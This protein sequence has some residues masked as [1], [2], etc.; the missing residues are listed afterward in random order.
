MKTLDLLSS[1]ALLALGG[2]V[3][4]MF[5][6]GAEVT[7]LSGGAIPK[8]LGKRSRPDCVNTKVREPVLFYDSTGSTLLGPSH[9]QLSVYNDGLVTV[10]RI[11]P[12]APGAGRVGIR[13]V[14]PEAVDN[15]AQSLAAAGASALCDDPLTVADM[16]LTTIT[17]CSLPGMDGASHTFSYWQGVSG[18]ALLVESILQGFVQAEFE[19]F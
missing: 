15:L 10:S 9:Y 12:L 14:S 6:F 4:T 16:P 17:V 19:G 3:C 8:Q 7:P 2:L 13:M 11:D 1:G 18:P 5:A